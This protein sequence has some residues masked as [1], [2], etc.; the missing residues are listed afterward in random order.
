ALLEVNPIA[1]IITPKCFGGNDG[2]ISNIQ[3]SGGTLQYHYLW[4]TTATTKDITDLKSGWYT[5]TVSDFHNCTAS[6]SFWVP[7][8]PSWTFEIDGF[9]PVCCNTSMVND[10]VTYQVINLTPGL[11]T[12]LTY[13]WVVTGGIIVEGQ[14]TPKI[15]VIW[16]CC[17]TGY[18]YLTVTQGPPD[19]CKLT[20]FRE[21]II[22]PTPA[23]VISGPISVMANDTAT[24]CVVNGDPTHL[25]SWDI[26]GI[27]TILS[28]QGT[29]CI[30]VIWGDYPPC[31][32]GEVYVCESTPVNPNCQGCTGLSIV[33]LPR[34]AN[35]DLYGTVYYKNIYGTALNGVTINLRDVATNNIV[36]TTVTGPNMNPPDYT[37]APGY[38]AFTVPNGNYKLEASFDGTWGG[39]NA[40]DA[41]LIQLEAGATPGTYLSGLYRKAAD[42]NGS[43]TVTALDALY[44][45]LRTVG[46]ITS[47][48]AGDWKFDDPNTPIP[49]I[50]SGPFDFYG[51]CFG[52]VNGSYIP[53]GLKELSFLSTVEDITQTI[54]VE[55]TFTYSIRSATSAKLGA[56]TLF[57]GYDADRFEVVDIA[58]QNDEM[59]Y[60]IENGTVAI[61]WADANPLSVQNE[62]QL[63]TLTV[64]AKVPVTEA[65]PIFSVKTGSEFA[66]GFGNRYDNF[67]LKM[68]KVI[69][70]NGSNE[71][72]IFNYPNPFSDNTRIVYTLPESGNVK[73]VIT[74]M[75]GKT[76]RTLVNDTQAAGSH[77]VTVNATDLHLSTGVYLYRIEVAGATENYVKVNKLIFAR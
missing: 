72:S 4:N 38:Y 16:S 12:P 66:D 69:T 5:V 18:V 39:N 55:E 11:P 26:V 47:Y 75:Y 57:M 21:I 44:V 6:N 33:I 25:Y 19:H 46:S 35:I 64:K 31:G 52:D 49:P 7:D 71:F 15:K 51:L 48:P 22:T 58:S 8:A 59:K 76:I 63:F 45:K 73:L 42:V 2:S 14:N 62:D 10:T 60:V 23:P 41:L 43:N 36:A 70:P 34:P 30:T 13:Q 9:S 1:D 27:D 29:S 61:A 53:T 24:Y 67:E 40:T 20:K 28:G 50:V 77:S 56:M 54:P 3:V 68:S 17:G 74:D 65:M 37:G 32:C